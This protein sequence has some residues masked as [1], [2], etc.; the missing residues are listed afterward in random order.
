MGLRLA[1]PGRGVEDRGA[2]TTRI[3]FGASSTILR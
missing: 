2:L 1:F 3:G